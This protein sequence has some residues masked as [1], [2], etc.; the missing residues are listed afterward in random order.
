MKGSVSQL[1]LRRLVPCVRD[2][3]MKDS[4]QRGRPSLSG[5]DVCI[6]DGADVF[7]GCVRVRCLGLGW[8]SSGL[9]MMPR[10]IAATTSSFVQR[11]NACRHDRD[12]GRKL[13]KKGYNVFL[14]FSRDGWGNEASNLDSIAS[15]NS[16]DGA[17]SRG[18]AL[19]ISQFR[20]ANS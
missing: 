6:I 8:R 7:G 5:C 3:D 17:D 16:S 11:T 20:V 1:F 14:T 4:G 18:G 9:Q 19:L 15:G 10:C 2:R 13:L 12:L